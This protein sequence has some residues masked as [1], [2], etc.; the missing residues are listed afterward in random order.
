MS[1]HETKTQHNYIFVQDIKLACILY[2]LGCRRYEVRPIER[3]MRAGKETCFFNFENT[4][5]AFDYTR[6]WESKED[7]FPDLNQPNHPLNDQDHRFWYMRAA[8]RNRDYLLAVVK[9]QM[10]IHTVV[11]GNKTYIIPKDPHGKT[12]AN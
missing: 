3:V 10:I 1:F 11:R 6:A 4:K 12:Y 2:A 7:K 5:E 9:E 8:L